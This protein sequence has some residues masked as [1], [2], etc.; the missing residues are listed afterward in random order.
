MKKIKLIV[1]FLIFIMKSFT[2]LAQIDT[3]FWFAAPWVTPD[4][5]W[6][7]AV[8][9][10]ISGPSGTTV[11]IRQPAA[12]LPNKYDTTF[13]IPAS[14]FFDYT[15]WRDAAAGVTNFG[16]DSLE[17]RPANAVRPYG[18]KVTS[19]REIT[20]VYDVVTRANTF[21]N[22]ETFS[23]K[24]RNGLGTEF[25]CPFQN[26]WFNQVLG[27][28]LNGD[29]VITQPRQ[30]INIVATLPNTVV[31]ITP[32]CNVVGHV[33]NLTY[34][35][36][37]NTGD[38]YTVENVTG[39]T[40]VA[41]QNLGGTIVV[42]NN[43]ISVTVADDSV[44]NP[45]GGC[46]DLIGDQIVPVDV[47]GKEYI[48]NKGFMF[49]ASQESIFVVAT[50][51]FTQITI[52][53]GT[54]T[55]YSINKGDVQRYTIT[56]PLTHI[57]ANK[58]V[59]LW[60]TTGYGC[61]S[62]AAILPPINCAG[63]DSVTFTRNNNQPFLLN[64]LC[65]TNG[66]INTPANFLLNG[67]STLVPASAFTLVPGTGGAWQGAQIQFNTTQIPVNSANLLSNSTDVFAMGVINGNTSTGGLFHYMSSFKRKIYSY[68][69]NDMSY[70]TG[71]NSVITLNGAINGGA[72]T[73]IWSVMN[74]TTAI[75][76]PSSAY[77]STVTNINATYTLTP[78]DT[79][80]SQ[81]KFV[82]LS[83]GNCDNVAD[84]VVLFIRKSPAVEA[85]PGMT[86]CK[87]NIPTINI[88]G[89]VLFATG[90]NW[91]TSGSGVFG[92]PTSYTT[93]Y[94]PSPS[95][96]SAG[97]VKLVLTSAGS[98][99]G[100]PNTN[101]SLLLTFTNP[102]TVNA[103]ADINVCTNS[104]TVN[105]NGSVGG[106]TSS[107]LWTT[108]GSGAFSPNDTLMSTTYIL[109]PND[110]TQSSLVI[111]LTSQNNG[112][113]N[114]VK[115]SITVFVTPKP[116]VLAGNNDTICASAGVI[117]LT[118]TVTGSALTGTWTT[119]GTGA[120]NNAGIL[121]P[122]Y[123]MSGAD[124]LAGVV[125]F[126][127]TSTGGICPP[128]SDTVTY[129]ILKAPLVAAGPDT[130]FCNNGIVQLNGLVSG[131]TT[132]GQ[133][134][135]TGT[136]TFVPN[137][138]SLNAAYFP[139]TSDV[140]NGSVKF[141]LES[142]N[143]KGCS[144]KRDSLTVTFIPSPTANF[145]FS[146]A[147]ATKPV[148]FTDLSVGSVSNYSWN[149]GDG[150][151]A[152]SQNPFHSYTL[153]NTYSVTF[154]VT[155]NNGCKDTV[156]KNVTVY[157]LPY[158]NFTYGP[159]CQGQLIQFQDS[160][161]SG[162]DVITN[163]N[164]NFADG[165]ISTSANPVHTYTASGIYNVNLNVTTDKGCTDSI[166][167]AVNV[168]PRPN[169]FFALTNNPTLAQELVYFTDFSTPAPTIVNWNW[170][171]GDGGGASSQNPT[172]IYQNQG[173]YTIT[174][175]VTDNFG[176]SDTSRKEIS[177][178][179]LPLVPTAFSPNGDNNNDLLFV[180]G[181]P[182]ENMN[183]RIYNNWGELI[184]ETTDQKVG[185]DGKYKGQDAPIGVYVWV[186]DV[187]MFN[188]KSVRKTGDVTLLR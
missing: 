120:F 18:L 108:L 104:P 110:L 135:S 77:T 183:F 81:I 85:G 31:W 26:N 150:G 24:G 75:S 7:D 35:V 109:S 67:S 83:T 161:L 53:D 60:Q 76:L 13:T 147:C 10:H 114:A 184:F 154:I 52:D 20:I 149:F 48:A 143:N 34:S 89:S 8:K 115:D 16:Y 74:G 57:T 146:V 91:T 180:K 185:W 95:D 100:C 187:D 125:Q 129:V 133:W 39:A 70:C 9:M 173:N 144:P 103:G 112:N 116:V 40:N 79:T 170:D 121:N 4:H 28:D 58:N 87:N 138:T 182:F 137:N 62:G 65:K 139:S 69:G 153:A 29:G 97:S 106:P 47:V 56:Q 88:T 12:I 119:S 17:S 22:P 140:I 151:T 136:G 38:V 123:T 113:C 155:S 43:P 21:Y 168:R 163:W 127:L 46:H 42:S 169:A 165:G 14:G 84:T 98:I 15:F 148:Q 86:I 99:F 25:V 132:T 179:L 107:G 186:L 66:A 162:V 49:P 128:E 51:N 159:A 157:N 5:T 3:V 172:N 72:S 90:G 94:V 2:S 102:P 160:S 19:S 188:N 93:T 55:T 50:D 6:R 33:A 181:G 68:A 117:A 61:E 174:L 36:L 141:I 164:W 92:N 80:Q 122:N 78:T 152:I 23:L 156:V 145:S 175:V 142:T 45:G 96:L 101:D 111:T 82:L 32:K 124:T 54:A 167:I 118:G 177:V 63:S 71:T 27:G 64:I 171:F 30:Q 44:R 130:S 158:A 126:I 131:F 11:R 37:M 178:T 41:G 166:N 105:L 176:C 73:G 1:L 134:I 59:Y